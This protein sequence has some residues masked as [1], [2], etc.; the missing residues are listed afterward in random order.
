ML[1]VRSS[2]LGNPGLPHNTDVLCGNVRGPL[3]F[4]SWGHD[5]HGPGFIVVSTICWPASPSTIEYIHPTPAEVGCQGM[6]KNTTDQ[7]P[8]RGHHE[9]GV[10]KGGAQGYKPQETGAGAVALPAQLSRGTMC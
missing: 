6:E 2:T 7:T 3:G 8:Q 4:H 10:G 5:K 1:C 9:Q